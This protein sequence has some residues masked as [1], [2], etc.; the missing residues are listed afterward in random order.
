[1]EKYHNNSFTIDWVLVGELAVGPAP[2]RE[3][4]LEKLEKLGIKVILSLCSEDE[5]HTLENISS[6]FVF[7][8]SL[9]PDHSY[10][11]VP[12][13]EELRNTLDTLISV[14]KLGPVFVHCFAGVERSPLVCIS[15]LV[16]ERKIPLDKA[17]DYLMEVH[18][19]TNPLSSQLNMI[20]LI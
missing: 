10:G 12:T 15:Y 19:G 7:K 16:K 2:R 11:R 5:S 4:H 6:R 1:M 20:K 13:L 9:L 17:L 18:P 3:K 8:R 14:K